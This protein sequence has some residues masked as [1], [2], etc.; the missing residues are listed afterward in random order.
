[1]LWIQEGR[2]VGAIAEEGRVVLAHAVEHR[3]RLHVGRIVEQILGLAYQ[4]GL[5]PFA[6]PRSLD[7]RVIG[8]CC[9]FTV[10]LVTLLRAQGAPACARC[11][12]AAYFEP[13]KFI[14]HWVAETWEPVRNRW[15]RVDA[16]L[17]DVQRSLFKVDFD[18]LDVPRKRFLDAGDAWAQCRSGALDPDAFGIL[19][20]HGLWFVAG[21]V[22]RDAAA[23][24]H[25][26]AALGLLG[27]DASARGGDGGGTACIL[28]SARRS[29]AGPG[30]G[31]RRAPHP[32]RHRRGHQGFRRGLQRGAEARRRLAAS[33][34]EATASPARATPPRRREQTREE[35]GRATSE[36]RKQPDTRGPL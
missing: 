17:D 8:T 12:F 31:L 10:L 16:Q 32:L 29:D 30:R 34:C 6:E 1:M 19:D 7:H 35:R 14:D 22:V 25:G 33:D 9:N 3:A 24:Q 18:P 2:F 26:D 27:S 5:R 11:G 36:A 20:M 15:V 28:R 23:L 4:R 21:N 13:G